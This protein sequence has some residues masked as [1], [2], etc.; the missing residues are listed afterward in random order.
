MSKRANP[1][2]IGAFVIGAVFLFFAALL[3]FGGAEL[4]SERERY[5]IY[6]HE[7]VNGLNIGAPVKMRGVQIGKV[8]EIRLIFDPETKQPL[9]RVV[10][11]IQKGHVQLGGEKRPLDTL[12]QAGLRAQLKLQSLVT[13]QL[14]VDIDFRPETPVNLVG[15]YNDAL[16]EIPAI[17]SSQ[18]EIENTITSLVNQI[19]ELPLQELFAKLDSTLTHINAVVSQPA[20]RELAPHLDT[21]LVDL[22]ASVTHLDENLR[23]SKR[24]LTH[25]DKALPA[26]A[27][28]S[29]AALRQTRQALAQAEAAFR[30]LQQS[31]GPQAPLTTEAQLTLQALQEAARELRVLSET[32]QTHPEALLQ[33]K[34]GDL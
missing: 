17:P 12:I 15:K 27:M 7:S 20:F 30:A 28:Q 2:V 33:G 8:A 34:G 4:W 29:E 16:E 24:T 14:Y 9:T 21:L 32:L 1:T 26:L 23:L 19:K 6:F 3:L 5:V 13:G 11:E 25:I 18:E 22:D 10:V 31:F